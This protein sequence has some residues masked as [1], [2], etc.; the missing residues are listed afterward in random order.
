MVTN[1]G[2][3]SNFSVAFPQN[4]DLEILSSLGPSVGSLVVGEMHLR[5]GNTLRAVK[6]A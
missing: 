6:G 4:F 2:H 5:F 1:V 3:S